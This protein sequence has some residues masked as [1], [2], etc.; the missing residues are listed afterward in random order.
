MEKERNNINVNDVY[1][2]KKPH[3]CG[4]N[5]WTVIKTGVDIKLKC[6]TCDRIIVLARYDFLKKFKK[7]VSE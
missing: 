1:M 5:L 7:K 3:P 4:G 2:M 6:N